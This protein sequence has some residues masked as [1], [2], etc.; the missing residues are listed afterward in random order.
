MIWNL[1]FK[2][3]SVLLVLTSLASELFVAEGNGDVS[4]AIYKLKYM[5]HEIL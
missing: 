5:P 2:K 4:F 3:N 1:K